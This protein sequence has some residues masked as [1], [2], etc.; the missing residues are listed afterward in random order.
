MKIQSTLF[1]SQQ[2]FAN[3]VSHMSMIQL[4]PGQYLNYTNVQQIEIVSSEYIQNSDI[5][6]QQCFLIIGNLLGYYFFIFNA[7][8]QLSN[9]P[10]MIVQQPM[11]FSF[12]NSFPPEHLFTNT[13]QHIR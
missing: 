5:V 1:D 3:K 6:I 7:D 4:F 2:Q 12:S 11:I 10:S 8:D 9:Q 13:K